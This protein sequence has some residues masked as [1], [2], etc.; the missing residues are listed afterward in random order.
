MTTSHSIERRRHERNIVVRPCK[1]RDRRSLLFSPGQTH[2]ISDG[3]MLVK[4]DSARAFSPGDEI[5]L[6]VAWNHDPV[7]ASEGMVKARVRRVFPID[8]HHQAIALEFDRSGI[9]ATGGL[10]KA[11]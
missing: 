2:D 1:V 3:G 4:V 7:L 10:A 9:A 5:E 8:Y 11:A 6:A